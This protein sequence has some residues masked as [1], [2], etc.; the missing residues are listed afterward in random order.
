[1]DDDDLLVQHIA[2]IVRIVADAVS[3]DRRGEPEDIEEEFFDGRLRILLDHEGVHVTA[4]LFTHS[5]PDT[6]PVEWSE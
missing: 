4:P 6:V 2:A 1:M 3:V 5:P